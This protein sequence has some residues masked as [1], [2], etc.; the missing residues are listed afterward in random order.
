MSTLG[1]VLLFLNLLV[2]AGVMVLAGMDY[3]A[4]RTVRRAA[5]LHEV[6]LIGLPVDKDDIH[7][8]FPDDPT[9]EKLTPAVLAD[10]FKGSDGGQDLGGPPVATVL[11]E[12]ERVRRK[13]ADNVNNAGSL[14][15]QKQKIR[16]YL[17]PMARDVAERDRL[18][19]LIDEGKI[20]EA[21][22]DL[23]RRFAEAKSPPGGDAQRNRQN[24]RQA[25]ARLLVN[26]NADPAWQDRVR[27]VVGIEA[28]AAALDHWA[29]VQ[30]QLAADVKSAIIRDQGNFLADYHEL[31][32]RILY[33]NENVQEAQR[34]LAD[35]KARVARRQTELQQRITEVQRNIQELAELTTATNTEIARLEAMQRDLFA[36]QQRFGLAL[37]ETYK[38]DEKL[39][40]MQGGSGR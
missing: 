4:F 28:A 7:S 37:E 29:H 27:L 31:L 22:E 10:L 30:E 33:E 8:E 40:Q 15:Q 23:D 13:V 2:A 5:F 34:M 17:L 36:L 32:R 20:A 12:L 25:T 3:G 6:T 11:D 16:G 18:K 19:K 14:D 9:T 26:L 21:L 39:K 35:E 24:V 1:K 38:L